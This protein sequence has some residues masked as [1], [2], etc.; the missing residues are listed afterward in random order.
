MKQAPWQWLMQLPAADA[1]LPTRIFQNRYK[2]NEQHS[3]RSETVNREPLSNSAL[4]CI[5]SQFV[6]NCPVRISNA[7]DHSCCYRYS[8]NTLHIPNKI[9]PPLK[10]LH[11]NLRICTL[12]GRHSGMCCLFSSVP[13]SVV[14]EKV[15]MNCVWSPRVLLPSF[16]IHTERSFSDWSHSVN[17][18]ASLSSSEQSGWLHG[19][20]YECVKLY[21][22]RRDNC[23]VAYVCCGQR[24]S[25]TGFASNTLGFLCHCNCASA[26]YSYFI[27]SSTTDAVQSC[28]WKGHQIKHLPLSLSLSLSLCLSRSKATYISPLRK[29]SSLSVCCYHKC[30][31]HPYVSLPFSNANIGY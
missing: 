1:G 11:S 22:H 23:S 25:G 12:H 17:V 3:S 9:P 29:Y 18:S 8:L 28:N 10:T 6:K 20:W 24:G 26:L 13:H 21:T 31:L 5:L 2:T 19:L 15:V 30:P 14:F 27:H 7:G 16:V 4:S